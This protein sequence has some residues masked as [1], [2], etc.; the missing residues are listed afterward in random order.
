MT[1][2][3]IHPERNLEK[4]N[5]FTTTFFFFWC[6]KYLTSFC[7]FCIT[8]YYSYEY[9]YMKKTIFV[10][11]QYTTT[12]LQ[13]FFSRENKLLLQFTSRLFECC[14]LFFCTLCLVI[15]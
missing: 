12:I 5:I 11:A 6:R 2:D 4:K 9:I 15:R 1:R 3:R 10:L 13:I 14:V 8:Y 7:V